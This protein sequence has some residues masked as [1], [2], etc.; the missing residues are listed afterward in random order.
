MDMNQAKQLFPS[1]YKSK[2]LE[3]ILEVDEGKEFNV[4]R[5]CKKG[6]IDENAFVPSNEE[7]S[8]ME[9][10]TNDIDK[11]INSYS[12]STFE[13]FNDIKRTLKLMQ[14]KNPKAKV[15]Y[16]TTV[17]SCGLSA[18]TKNY[19]KKKNAKSHIDWWVFKNS[20]P[21]RYFNELEGDIND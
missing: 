21:H 15:A 16:G 20:N 10:D 12:V 4:Y 14:R 18:H 17:R 7:F 11:T 8:N 13:K 2:E 9:I 19:M 1:Y 3:R 5:I 6:I